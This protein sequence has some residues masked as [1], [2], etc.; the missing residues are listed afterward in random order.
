M[1]NQI[2]MLSMGGVWGY[3]NRPIIFKKT[4]HRT[5][6]LVEA[7]FGDADI[8]EQIERNRVVMAAAGIEFVDGR[9]QP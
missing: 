9:K 7:P 5:L 8:D 6:T 2:A 4:S 1:K 3:E